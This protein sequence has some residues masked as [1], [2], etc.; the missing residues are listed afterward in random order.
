MFEKLEEQIAYVHVFDCE[1]CQD[2]Q[3]GRCMGGHMACVWQIVLPQCGSSCSSAGQVLVRFTVWGLG[4]SC[5]LVQT[6]SHHNRTG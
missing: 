6:C 3:Y 2:C 1:H 4:V 5:E